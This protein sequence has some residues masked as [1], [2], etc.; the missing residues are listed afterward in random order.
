MTVESQDDLT[1]LTAGFGSGLVASRWRRRRWGVGGRLI[2]AFVAV[3]AATVMAGGVA[4]VL[5]AQVRYSLAVITDDNLPTILASLGVADQANR[6]AVVVPRLGA[7]S[8][9]EQIAAPFGEI[10]TSLAAI[11]DLAHGLGGRGLPDDMLRRIADEVGPFQADLNH[12]QEVM[13]LALSLRD[14][15]RRAEGGILSSHDIF[16]QALIPLA[17]GGIVS[18]GD[19][20]RILLDLNR[21][22]AVLLAGIRSNDLIGL[23]VL[24]RR[25]REISSQI[26]SRLEVLRGVEISGRD[27]GHLAT[28][29]G[30]FT[31][32]ARYCRGEESLFVTRRQELGAHAEADHLI[33][34]NQGR[35][36]SLLAAAQF[37]VQTAEATASEAAFDI[38]VGIDR[39]ALLLITIISF[40]VLAAVSVV[41]L[42]VLPA[43]VQRLHRL[44]EATVALAAGR[45]DVQVV[46]SGD[47]EITDMARSLEVF[48]GT[49]FERQRALI[50]L[51]E[52]QETLIQ[53]EKMAALGGLVAGVAHEIN[54]PL[55][56]GLGAASLLDEET[57]KLRR[58]FDADDITEEEFREYIETA[59]ESCRL[60]TTNLNRAAGLVNSFKQVAVDQTS[61]ARRRY[62]LAQ[63]LD[64]ILASLAP[65]WKKTGHR[66][67]VSC[68]PCLVLD[69]YPGAMSQIVTN[70]VINALVHGLGDG[71]AAR[72]NGEISIAVSATPAAMTSRDDAA[73][74]GD[75]GEDACAGSDREGARSPALAHVPV[76]TGVVELR[77]S[78]NGCG[79]PVEVLPRIFDP[80]F[81]T[82]RGEGGSGLGLN[83]VYNLVTGPLG[84]RI[85]VESELGQGTTFV[86]TF[87][88]K[89]PVAAVTVA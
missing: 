76:D 7:V 21:L 59:Q 23:E 45:L 40:G 61:D 42:Y 26:E 32:I 80:F 13:A 22:V 48:R 55:G 62:D 85:R 6:L 30:R 5:F 35:A 88:R 34:T 15:L 50:K 27:R 74:D 84:G 29:D 58:L 38:R 66:V 65:R 31:E 19:G 39:G 41:W 63:Y 46:S 36:T 11:A 17:S 47:D 68:P 51:R 81:T 60:M 18:S 70:L 57:R 82:R 53:A 4:L 89:A 56:I 52:A 71:G 28:M 2:A 73:E 24:E 78:D 3:S 83:I 79:I 10:A 77:I 49:A 25:A 20:G 87:P 33:R 16:D 14:R 8:R 12:L 64:E 54:T 72:G 69:G 9:P 75:G 43:I 67:V 86:L 44:A 1:H 37:L